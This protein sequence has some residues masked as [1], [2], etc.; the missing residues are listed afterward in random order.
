MVF[1]R[2]VDVVEECD[3]CRSP[4]AELLEA[5]HWWKVSPFATHTYEW[6]SWNSR[7]II[8][9]SLRFFGHGPENFVVDA[10][11]ETKDRDFSKPINEELFKIALREAINAHEG[12]LLLSIVNN[13]KQVD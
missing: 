10:F 7:Q 12:V 8:E 2:A 11:I 5:V 9:E 13:L 6:E 1:D 4:P 3:S